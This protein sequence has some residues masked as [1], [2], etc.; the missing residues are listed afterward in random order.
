MRNHLSGRK[1]GTIAFGL[2]VLAARQ[3]F[4]SEVTTAKILIT[5][6]VIWAVV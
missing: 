3:A 5:T 1:A 2:L 4:G 6:M